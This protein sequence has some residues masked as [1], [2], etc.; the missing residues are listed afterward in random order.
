MATKKNSNVPAKAEE[1]TTAVTAFEGYAE[2]EGDGFENQSQDDIAIPFM[3][4]LQALSPEVQPD[5]VE[6]AKA[7]MFINSVT[8]ELHEDFVFVPAITQH[9]FVEWVPRDQGGGIVGTHSKDSEIVK[10]AKAGAKEFGK[11]KTED[12]NDLVETFYLFGIVVQDEVPVSMAVMAFTSTKIKAYRAMTTRCRTF[13]VQVGDRRMTPPLF[14]HQ[15]RIKSMQ[16]KNT[17]GTFYVPTI[18]PAVDGDIKA[19][20]LTTDDPRFLMGK[21]C[22]DMVMEGRAKA[23]ESSQGGAEQTDGDEKLPF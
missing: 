4:L 19:S 10:V 16:Q 9:V 13:Q 22:R 18:T 11:Y 1:K 12:G 3:N 2:Y 5:G 15:L 20:L 17:K 23:D 14:A 8:Q 6:G 7:G 21:Q